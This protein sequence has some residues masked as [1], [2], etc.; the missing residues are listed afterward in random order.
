MTQKYL[1]FMAGN[2]VNSEGFTVSTILNYNSLQLESDHA[3]IQWIFPLPEPSRF[4]PDAPLI[5]VKELK[6]SLQQKE[7]DETMRQVI[8]NHERATMMMLQFWGIE[9]AIN[10]KRITCLNGHN[11]LRFSRFL[12]CLVYHGYREKA[13]SILDQI[14]GI[15]NS[16]DGKEAKLLKPSINRSTG[17]TLWEECYLH[18]CDMMD[19]SDH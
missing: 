2:I 14:L 16:S 5:D 4:N 1:Q 19:A 9:P 7:T 11:G 12:Q 13:K 8:E 6:Q 18:A 10:P 3:F 17:K 15:V